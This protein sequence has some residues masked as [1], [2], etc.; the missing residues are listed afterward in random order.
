V[1][2]AV[3]TQTDAQLLRQYVELKSQPA[4]AELAGRHTHWIYSSALRQVRDPHTAEDVVQA[5]FIVLAR[6]APELTKISA[7]NAWLFQVTRYAAGHALRTDARRKH[8]E[9]TAASMNQEMSDRDGDSL[10]QEV[11]P[12]LDE[13]IA[14]M[15]S[16]DRQALLL[17]F[18]QQKSM[19]EVGAALNV[20]EDAA[21]KRVARAVEQLRSS[22]NRTGIA[23]P[24]AALAAILVTSTTHPASASLVATCAATGVSSAS[25][26][27]TTIA[28]GAGAAMVATKSKIAVVLVLLILLIP[29]AGASI[30][31]L[32]SGSDS[33]VNI[34]PATMPSPV[35][36]SARSTAIL[37]GIWTGLCLKTHGQSGTSRMQLRVTM[38]GHQFLVS[39]KEHNENDS[40][41]VDTSQNPPHIDILSGGERFEGIFVLDGDNL[42]I[43]TNAGNGQRPVDFVAGPFS[44]HR[45]A[46][47]ARM[48]TPATTQPINDQSSPTFT[49]LKLSAALRDG[50]MDDVNACVSFTDNDNPELGDALRQ[51]FTVNAATCRIN[52]MW[53]K[54]FNQRMKIEG[55]GFDVFNG[56]HGSFEELI[57]KAMDAARADDT[58]ITGDTA[59]V[60]LHLP[61][62]VMA[63]Y[64][65]GSWCESSLVFHRKNDIWQLD[66]PASIRLDINLTPRQP[67]GFTTFTH[68]NTDLVKIMDETAAAIA[69]GH[70]KTA[71]EAS[72]AFNKEYWESLHG[73]G[74][75]NIVINTLPNKPA[76]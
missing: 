57:D 7:L 23:V 8:H 62:D 61:R 30:Y 38:T 15:R 70:F 1:P 16:E 5:V 75:A 29:A 13:L 59:T 27:A 10:W 51:E 18:Y 68:T 44:D 34:S 46:F 72:D 53:K 42:I 55:F 37:Q 26:A 56:L 71:R 11:Q 50:N 41:I 6:K 4:F 3:E 22:L 19:A 54:A 58:S 20:S 66:A 25:I 48:G 49:L 21:K 45:L 17:R 32:V 14:R 73:A 33:Q 67:D 64:G 24:G 47:L 60:R 69:A 74:L 76:S 63:P 43:R 35:E 39:D 40:F 52:D 36:I 9:R 12:H 31:L 28:K 2:N 65:Q